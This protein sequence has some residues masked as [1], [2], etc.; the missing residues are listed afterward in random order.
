MN[1]V[2]KLSLIPIVL[3]CV[4]VSCNNGSKDSD[5]TPI[6]KG[7]ISAIYLPTPVVVN[8]NVTATYLLTGG[9]GFSN[10]ILVT[11]SSNPNGVLTPLNDVNTCGLSI[12]QPT[13]TITFKASTPGSTTITSTAPDYNINSSFTNQSFY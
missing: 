9:S 8:G 3:S 10:S 4:L 13:C 7:T 2:F 12:L 6:V 1:Q 11:A 5:P